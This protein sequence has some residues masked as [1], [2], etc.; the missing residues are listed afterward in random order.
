MP[1][2]NG[3]Q[4]NQQQPPQ[5]QQNKPTQAYTSFNNASNNYDDQSKDY[6]A[7]A[8]AGNNQQASLKSSGMIW[9]REIDLSKI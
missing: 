5:Y 4:T 9:I 3:S 8:N 1:I 6:S 2:P 7:Y